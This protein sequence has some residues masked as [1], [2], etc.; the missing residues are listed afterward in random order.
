MA[1]NF[2]VT[3][4]GPKPCNASVQACPL[5][6]GDGKHF[7]TKEEAQEHFEKKNSGSIL[8]KLKRKKG[9]PD[10]AHVRS[11]EKRIKSM[12]KDLKA[13]DERQFKDTAYQQILKEVSSEE[14]EEMLKVETTNRQSG[15]G[16]LSTEDGDDRVVGVSYEGDHK[17]EEEWGLAAIT[18]GLREGKFEKD[19]VEYIEQKGKGILIIK[20]ESTYMDADYRSRSAGTALSRFNNYEDWDTKRDRWK[21]ERKYGNKK[22]SEI[23]EEFKGKIK[24]LPTKRDDLIKAVHNFENGTP[25][26]K[27]TPP[28]GEFQNGKVLSIVS[29]NKAMMATMRKAKEAHDNG[30][31]RVGSSN[32]PFSN[33]VVFYDDRDVSRASKVDQVKAEEANAHA[34]KMIED[35]SAALKKK[36][37]LYYAG[38]RLGGDIENLKDARYWVNYSPGR[39]QSSIPGAE[40]QVFGYFSR[41]DIKEMA[42]DDFS[43]VKRNE[44][45]REKD[46]AEAQ[47]RSDAKKAAGN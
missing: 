2:H 16:Y 43:A 46:I 26:E 5:K 27:I 44:E 18:K 20:G 32:N 1:N 23:R 25:E 21:T 38:A 8:Q 11:A 13:R 19:D 9:D 17:A 6:D 40:K 10:T 42:N 39:S 22:V 7:D 29:D 30:S 33:G 45:K 47:A 14:F 37:S 15:I 34:N 36:G 35:D 4:D 24:P 41:D 28:Q 12:E 31:L 3:E